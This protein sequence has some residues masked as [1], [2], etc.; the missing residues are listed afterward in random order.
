MATTVTAYPFDPTGMASS[1]L[2]TGERQILVPPDWS[3]YYFILP[4]ATPFFA[5]G[6]FQLVL[7]PS[8]KVLQEGVDYV[9]CYRFYEATIQCAYPVY[10][11]IYFMDK[12]LSGIVQLQYQTLGGEWTLDSTEIAAVLANQ[13]LNPLVTTWEEVVNLP[14]QFPPVA[15]Q[16]NIIDMTGATAI[17]S[18]LNQ[19]VTA[20]LQT[21]NAGLAAHLADFN[22]PHRVTATQVGLGNVQ[23]YGMAANADAVAGTSTALY[24]SPATTVTAIST[25]ALAPLNAHIN[26]TDNPHFVTAVQVGLGNVQNYGWAATANAQAGIATTGYMNPANTAAAIAT[27]ALTPLNAHISNTDNPHDVTATQIGLGNV[28]N[29]PLAT[30]AQAQAGTD[31]ATYMTPYLVS[32]LLGGTSGLAG[33]L[34]AHIDN[35]SN[36]HEV[37]ATQVGLGSVQNY[38][39]AANA[40]AVAGTATNLYMS[41]ATTA[42][43]ITSQVGTAFE[44]HIVDYSNPHQVTSVEVGLGNVQNYPIATNAQAQLGTATNLYMTPANTTAAITTQVGNSLAAHLVNY[45]NPHQVTAAQVGA[46]TT[47]YIDTQINALSTGKLGV[48][49]EAANS[50]LLQGQDVQEIIASVTAGLPSTTKILYPPVNPYTNTSGVT[51]N[52]GPT[53]TAIY[54]QPDYTPSATA[55]LAPITALVQGGEARGNEGVSPTYLVEIDPSFPANAKVEC[56]AGDPMQVQFGYVLNATGGLTLYAYAPALRNTISMLMISDPLNNNVALTG[57][58]LDSAPANLVTMSQL[59]R[60]PTVKRHL[61]GPSE[62]A[63]PHGFDYTPVESIFAGGVGNAASNASPLGFLSVA[64]TSAEVTSAQAIV[65]PWITEWRNMGRVVAYGNNAV[66]AASPVGAWGWNNTNSQIVSSATAMQAISTLLSSEPLPVM[67]AYQM[68]I[69]L[70]STDLG[71]ESI[72]VCFGYVVADGVTYALQALRTPGATVVDA[73]NGILPGFN[74]ASFG[75]FTVGINL[76]ETNGQVLASNTSALT[77]GDGTAGS[78]AGHETS[79]V[80]NATTAGTNGWANKG[81]VRIRITYDGVST[82]TCETTDFNDTTG[83]Y[84]AGAALTL[85]LATT[86]FAAGYLQGQL[87]SQPFTNYGG[88]RW[89]LSNYNQASC[90]YGILTC[91]DYY[92]R[93]VDYTPGTDGTDPSGL[94]Y[95]SGNPAVGT[96]GWSTLLMDTNPVLPGR[97]LYSDVNN[98]I[99]VVRRDGTLNPLPIIAYTGTAGSQILTT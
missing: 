51:I 79:Y 15:H 1:N 65:T 8:G 95:Y 54:A 35:Y 20:L 31:N 45:D 29:Y 61:P 9:F 72:G 22:N 12:T 50:A 55:P 34:E 86:T 82:F 38:G 75:L 83:A 96:S 28:Q 93:Y 92:A 14:T 27:Q 5:N 7:Q 42:A 90:A 21:G 94:Y 40:D 46:Y 81:V 70:S 67:G 18:V 76:F 63:F 48:N 30:V 49:A 99:W 77:W 47:A 26:N 71:D 43:A 17:V 98:T 4:L 16:W 2:I 68:E 62:I 85:D 84:V 6:N 64:T 57:T 74:M 36:P 24:M 91:P 60:D 25:F 87:L 11:G 89:G 3:D 97:L 88:P 23:N 10:G 58:A 33:Q 73:V 32:Q 52:S 78:T 66:R 69:E 59:I 56:L 41:P 37:T 39:M 53:W 19:I 44:A 80:P 13:L